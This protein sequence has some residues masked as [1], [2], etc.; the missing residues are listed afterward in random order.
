MKLQRWIYVILV[1]MAVYFSLMYVDVFPSLMLLFL[2]CLGVFCQGQAYYN[3]SNVSMEMEEQYFIAKRNEPKTIHFSLKNEKK[4]KAICCELTIE[5]TDRARKQKKRQV[6]TA[7]T[8]QNSWSDVP[9]SLYIDEF[10]FFELQVKQ[11]RVLDF[12]GLLGWRCKYSDKHS[13]KIL[14]LPEAQPMMLILNRI[15]DR[16]IGEQDQ[17]SMSKAGNDPSQV[18]NIRNY[19]D[20]DRIQQIHWKLSQKMENLLVKEFSMPLGWPAKIVL[21]FHH[22][23]SIFD[24][25]MLETL[26][27][28][29]VA[30][31]E[32]EIR[33]QIVWQQENGLFLSCTSEEMLEEIFHYLFENKLSEKGNT[34]A[35]YESQYPQTTCEHLFYLTDELTEENAYV[36]ERCHC[37][38]E[39]TVFCMGSVRTD[40]TLQ[41]IHLQEKNWKSELGETPIIF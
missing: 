29:C 38:N 32:L 8:Q 18:F 3:A 27:S 24:E 31:M 13:V 34:L 21:D 6:V 41:I 25:R 22:Q 17:F 19:Q 28:L 1:V 30:L 26:L 10:G 39:T 23:E 12:L 7:W 14:I 16:T 20:G 11:V 15:I 36:L 4:Q 9:I 35:E 40:I 2:L 37:A 33:F 5:I